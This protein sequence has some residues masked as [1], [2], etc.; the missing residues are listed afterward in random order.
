[1]TVKDET[2][3]RLLKLADDRT[4]PELQRAEQEAARYRQSLDQV[5]D[6]S[7]AGAFARDLR[8]MFR[9]FK[10]A[11]RPKCLGW[12]K[13]IRS[14]LV[15]F[16][17]LRKPF[18]YQALTVAREI[19]VSRPDEANLTTVTRHVSAVDLLE[20]EARN[21]DVRDLVWM[22]GKLARNIH[23]VFLPRVI[24]LLVDLDDSGV[25]GWWFPADAAARLVDEFIACWDLVMKEV[26]LLDPGEMADIWPQRPDQP[27]ESE[28]DDID[29]SGMDA[30][31]ATEY[32]RDE[33]WAAYRSKLKG[34]MPTI[35]DPDDP[36]PLLPV[37]ARLVQLA[38]GAAKGEVPAENRDDATLDARLHRLLAVNTRFS[39]VSYEMPS[40]EDL[41]NGCDDSPIE[42]ETTEFT[43]ENQYKKR[44]VADL[45]RYLHTAC[46]LAKAR[47]SKAYD[48]LVTCQVLESKWRGNF[49]G[50]RPD[51]MVRGA[52]DL[53][54]FMACFK[55]ARSVLWADCANYTPPSETQPTTVKI[56]GYT[57]QGLHEAVAVANAKVPGKHYFSDVNLSVLFDVHR[58]TI[59]RWRKKPSSAP[60]G[61]LDALDRKDPDAMRACAEKSK[62]DR[63]KT[64]ALGRKGNIPFNNDEQVYKE[65]RKAEKGK[66][67]TGNNKKGCRVTFRR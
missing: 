29:I 2:R 1:M 13:S 28:M 59:Y 33:A 60:P 45:D 44:I 40:P 31:E 16:L 57:P 55:R 37:A 19:D 56:A 15:Q 26:Q 39:Y 5:R 10:P 25:V 12:P 65:L 30:D 9:C 51:D 23:S 61:F 34:L 58:N 32:S 54:T 62:A 38:D 18:P 20:A 64:D 21:Q 36:H 49:F 48:D 46:A 22:F 52:R 67:G 3:A 27:N 6:L 50:E 63:R 14:A 53:D 24:Q 66:A 41:E 8:Y 42:S 7:V 17:Q 47:G 43:D 35:D 4:E 11:I